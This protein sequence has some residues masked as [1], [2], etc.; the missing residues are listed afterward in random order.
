MKFTA[1]CEL[2]VGVDT[3]MTHLGSAMG[4]SYSRHFQRLSDRVSAF[5]GR[6]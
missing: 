1:T 5:D 6:G 2:V 3:G 4:A